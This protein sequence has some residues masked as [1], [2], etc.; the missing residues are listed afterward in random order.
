MAF[1]IFSV[2][3]K[4]LKRRTFRTLIL[5]LSIGLLVSILVFGA[6]FVVSV[7][8]SIKRAS[9]RLGADILVVPSGAVSFAE[10]VLLDTNVDSLFMSMDIV[11]RL[12]DIEGVKDVTHQTYLTSIL[13][14]CCDIPSAKIVIFDH[15]TDFIV[16]PWLNKVIGRPL[17]K[18]EVIIGA[19]AYENFDLLDVDRSIFF[20][21]VFDIVGVL[22]ETGTGLDNAMLM[23][24]VN[25]KDIVEK[26]ALELDPKDV[27]LAFLRLKPGYDP[28]K[29]GYAIEG[30]MLEV[31]VI[32]RT[33]IGMRIINNLRD[34]AKVFLV[35]TVLAAFLSMFLAWSVFSAIANERIREVGIMRAI[36][37]RGSHVMWMFI[38]EVLVLGVLG[39]I[40]GLAFGSVLYLE[41]SST[42]VLLQNLPVGLSNAEVS[43]IALLGLS[44]GTFVCLFGA[45][46][47]IIRLSGREP[48]SS[49]KEV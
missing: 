49:I 26:S 4:N 37:A 7:S 6:S 11:D 47:S 24:D 39:S 14:V 36:G 43:L 28:E 29:V 40:L 19:T 41:L 22:E 31:D 20:N 2:A 18:H 34:V 13:A 25:R 8:A 3:V 35:T 32:P 30:E 46:S 45:L 38:L 17:G 9:D 1:N 27:S 5:I 23:S 33:N 44:F 10:E 15:D 16:K 21:V 48:F 42:F 12:K